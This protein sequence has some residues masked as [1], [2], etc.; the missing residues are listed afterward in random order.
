MLVPIAL[1][2]LTLVVALAIALFKAKRRII[3]HVPPP[4]DVDQGDPRPPTGPLGH[5]A[6][7]G[8]WSDDRRTSEPREEVHQRFDEFALADRA[9]S[10]DWRAMNT[11]FWRGCEWGIVATLAMTAVLLLVWKLS[12]GAVPAPLPLGIT[13]GIV[14]RVF[15]V[16]PMTP[17]VLILGTILQFAYGAIW[18]GLLG[19]IRVETVGRGIALGLGLWLMMLI[20]YMP[21]AGIDVFDVATSKGIWIATLIGHLI[22]GYTLGWLLARDQR[23]SS[24]R[25]I[26]AV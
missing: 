21:M 11:R 8:T 14:A 23:R 18:G 25:E 12:P 2:I 5:Y 15:D 3:D 22:Y 4:P 20:F 6:A 9:R 13:V 24:P 7:D 1:L 17:G 19:T 16:Q 10:S 26:A